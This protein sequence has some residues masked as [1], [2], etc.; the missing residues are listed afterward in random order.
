[1]LALGLAIVLGVSGA[2]C[3]TVFVQD[4]GFRRKLD[5]GCNSY[6]SC[7]ALV[8]EGQARTRDCRDNEVGRV[9]CDEAEVDVERA[10]VLLE[11]Y[12]R[13]EQA[14]RSREAQERAE[15]E[16]QDREAAYAHQEQLRKQ[17]RQ[18][19]IAAATAAERDRRLRPYR[20]MTPEAREAYLRRC[21]RDG[22]ERREDLEQYYRPC[23]VL[24]NELLEAAASE[25]EREALMASSEA[26]KIEEAQ[27]A[28]EVAQEAAKQEAAAAKREAAAR[29]QRSSQPAST[30]GSHSSSSGALRCCDGS[31]SPS[32]TCA[33]SRR[34]CCSH[35]GGV[36]GCTN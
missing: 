14:R 28:Q 3:S 9:R 19:E 35:H 29:Q 24:L 30:S 1:M 15:R 36:C 13:A 22:F 23:D 25:E 7:N 2:G 27:A 32:C 11:P 6:G 5:V 31:I 10:H 4:D 16:R 20:S 33:G 18:A 8:A 26:A 34:G 12:A 21:Y 17:K